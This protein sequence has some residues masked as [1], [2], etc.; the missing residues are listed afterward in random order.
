MKDERKNQAE[1]LVANLLSQEKFPVRP[2]P[3]DFEATLHR[4][5]IE[6]A[7]TAAHQPP[8]FV[9]WSALLRLT[10]AAFSFIMV[11]LVGFMVGSTVQKGK[12]DEQTSDACDLSNDSPTPTDHLVAAKTVVRRGEPVTIRLVYDSAQD[13]GKVRFMVVL[14]SG[15]RFR[16]N[17]PEIATRTELSW[18]G[19]LHAGRNEIPIVVTVD[20]AGERTIR[21]HAQFN[22]TFLEQKVILVAR[23][24]NHA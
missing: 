1:R 20:E 9:R 16:S 3:D 15:I 22:G 12:T 24:D 5:L 17:N 21:A 19:S 4:R 7:E 18:E 13:I 2:L 10:A 14:D 8:S 6:A 23:E 11:F